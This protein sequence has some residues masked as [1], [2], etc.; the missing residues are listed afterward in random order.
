MPDARDGSRH[1]G[2]DV[3]VERPVSDDALLADAALALL[4]CQTE[5][6]VFEILGNVILGLVPGGYV[7]VNEATPNL[8]SLI[9]RK[10]KGVQQSVLLK[11]T[12][13]LGIEIVGR[14]FALESSQRQLLLGGTLVRVPGG[15]RELA[16]DGI[17]RMLA[18]ASAKMF[19]LPEVHVIGISD[20]GNSMG[21]CLI[22]SATSTT[23]MPTHIIE[24]LAHHCCSVLVGIRQAREAAL[25]ARRDRLL[26][27]SMSE[28]LALHEI[29]L[30][31]AGA[32]CDYRFID[33][34]RAYET[35]T[36][37]KGS[38]IAGRTAREVMPDIDPLWIERYGEVALTGVSARFDD[39]LGLD[40]RHLRVMAYSPQQ[41]QFATLL[42][43]VTESEDIRCAL[44]LSE[45]KFATAFRT[46][47]DAVNIN[48]LADGMYLDVNEG[49]TALTG[50]TAAD[51]AGK[52]SADIRIWDDPADRD[53]LVAGLRSDGLVRNLEA[54]FRR[55]DGQCVTALMSAQIID[56]DGERCILSVTRDISERI[57]A[58]EA[59]RLTAQQLAFALAA[60]HQGMY[61][62]N[63]ATG[64]A[65]VTPEYLTMLGEPPTPGEFDL[66]AFAH[67]IHPDDAALVTELVEAYTRGDIDEY[68]TDYRIRH[69]E[70]HWIWVLSI[71]RVV[72]RDQDGRA[73]RVLGSHTDITERKEAEEALRL[74]ELLLA[75]SIESQKDTSLFSIDP[76]YRYLFFNSAHAE[77]MRF[78][79]GQEI[80]LGMNIL[81]R[82][83]SEEDRIAAKENYDRAL[84]GESQSNIQIYGDIALAYYESFF[85][86]IVD[87]DGAIIGATGL[88][89]DITER[90]REEARAAETSS[91]L[92]N[93][94]GYANAPIIVW[95]SGLRITRFNPAFEELTGRTA[96]EVLG[97]PLSILFPDEHTADS[98]ELVTSASAGERWE[99]VEI[100]ILHTD[101]TVRTVLWNSAPI[102][103]IDGVTPIA[104][105]AQG[106]DI[107]ARKEAEEA[108]RA[109]E[110]RMNRAQHYAHLGSW[111]WNIATGDL[112]WSDE[113]FRLFGLERETFTGVLADV[114]DQAIHPDDREAVEASNRSVAEDGRPQPLKYRVVWP[115]GSVHV[116]WAEAGELVL[117]SAGEP[118]VLSG[119]VQDITARSKVEAELNDAMQNLERSNRDLEQFAYIASHDLRE[120]LRMVSIYTELLRTRYRGSLDAD[121][122]DFIDFAVEGAIRMSRLLEDLLDYSRVGSQGTTPTPVETQTAVDQ[123][124]ANLHG[125]IEDT[126]TEVTVGKMPTVM[127]DEIQLMRVFQNLIN[128]A[129]KFSREDNPPRISI[130]AIKSGRLWQFCIKDNGVGIDSQYHD[131]AFEIFRR[132]HPR[133]AYPGTG[134]GLAICRRIIERFGGT[135]WIE[136]SDD[137]GTT[138]C[139]TLPAP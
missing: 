104:T 59:R 101:G 14:S 105:I 114:I 134:V 26:L 73:I 43:D 60:T 5:D 54:V 53:R 89:R 108:L 88:A 18:Q 69:S 31:D 139:F 110:T 22:F 45:A 36:G 106:Q 46:G 40:G 39:E 71:G 96:S 21:S 47:P 77:A 68:R 128:N 136:Q 32:P 48:R 74:S 132:L 10:I 3:P 41:G 67:R 6:D 17:P 65:Q 121:A 19:D 30:D 23:E 16:Q 28:G 103:G 116:V 2:S 91:Y 33:V 15:L 80:A 124:L 107:T 131:Q 57:A 120:P 118:A 44:A 20:G 24:S 76:E 63:V 35:M 82:I 129:I 79:Y 123:A 113:M 4:H 58:E 127:A 84:Q 87:A 66:G 38:D 85:N 126:G 34:N 72:E 25:S 109:S 122:D 100:Q 50:Y 12:A 61:D 9:P 7:I 49:F 97:E 62:L 137:S 64:V 51:V 130:N 78:A 99:V 135:I 83:T 56:V 98:L 111:T 75:A 112:E 8:E 86:P 115:D 125:Q 27:E 133:D 94:F 95:D 11:L 90:K 81:D 138:F 29:I 55:K 1:P 119:T 102:F 52:T 117:D 37:M 92:E 42:E 70:G 93:L 13:A